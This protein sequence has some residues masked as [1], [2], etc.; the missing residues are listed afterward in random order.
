MKGGGLYRDRLGN[1][2]TGKDA[3]GYETDELAAIKLLRDNTIGKDEYMS[4]YWARFKPTHVLASKAVHCMQHLCDAYLKRVKA[5]SLYFD[6]SHR[7]YTAW[8]GNAMDKM[9]QYD[10]HNDAV[11]REV[12]SRYVSTVNEVENDPKLYEAT[13]IPD[14]EP[15]KM[16]PKI[17][18]SQ[19]TPR[20]DTPPIITKTTVPSR[21]DTPELL[22]TTIR[23]KTSKKTVTA[24]PNMDKLKGYEH[25][26]KHLSPIIT[27][28]GVNHSAREYWSEA[29]KMAGIDQTFVKILESMGKAKLDVLGGNR[30]RK[31]TRRV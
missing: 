14:I 4:D 30:K 6:R 24:N 13:R 31:R 21:P 16:T 26:L 28:K 22:L 8:L 27:A 18:K 3:Y 5:D 10:Y 9:A 7:L 1:W 19:I 2:K 20:P 23:P 17:I 11:N 29:K 25:L 15:V 12:Q